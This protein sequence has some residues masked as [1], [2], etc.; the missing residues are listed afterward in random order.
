MRMYSSVIDDEFRS[1]IIQLPIVGAGILKKRIELVQGM[2][3][4][5]IAKGFDFSKKE[6][7][8]TDADKLEYCK[9]EEDL[10]E[11]WRKILKFQVLSRYLDALEDKAQTAKTSDQN[12][13]LPVAPDTREEKIADDLR[14]EASD[15]VLKSFE[16]F[17]TRLL[18]EDRD[19]H[20]DRYFNAVAQA[21]DPHTNYLPP[22]KKED[23]DIHMRGSLEGIGA[24]LR[25][26]GGYIKIV[27]VIPG[28]AADRQ[29]QLQ[30]E[31]IILKVAEGDGEPVDITDTRIR[32]AVALIR[33][34]KGTEVRLT[35]K[36]PDGSRIIIPIIRD[37]V[38]IE[39]T[40]VKATIIKDEKRSK[41]Y[42]YIK[43]PSFYRDF[44]RSMFSGPGRNV[45]DDMRQELKNLSTQKTD[46]LI[47][48]LRNNGGGALEDAVNVAG[49]FIKTGPIVQVK[50]SDGDIEVLADKDAAIGYDGPIVVLVSKFSASASEILAAALQDYGRAV[51]IGGEHTHGKG[52]VQT[53]IDLNNHIPFRNMEKFKPLGAL[54]ITTQKFY[55]ISGGS[56]QYR[57]VSP[58]IVL[59][60]LMQYMKSGEQYYDF[61]LPWD[62]VAPTSYSKWT[63]Q[64]ANLALLKSRSSQRVH[65]NQDFIEIAEE[66]EMAKERSEKTLRSLNIDEVRNDLEAERLRLKEKGER[67]GNNFHVSDFSDDFSNPME[68]KNEKEWAE[69]ISGDP[70]VK[71]ATFVLYDMV[72][73]KVGRSPVEQKLGSR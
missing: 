46:G 32:D 51:V 53:M 25:E 38:Q 68:G 13:N 30:A 70:Y 29:G 11:R 21:F 34:K 33:G 35:V 9:N 4:D 12:Q 63:K 67:G 69:K 40:F 60:D 55:R 23:F 66:A 73:A 72:D 39:E 54:K 45:T 56:T 41:N 65:D 43:I 50:D 31:D 64:T 17:F 15:K 7:I 18:N 44:N 16:D 1:G 6:S 20:Y 22:T 37:I 2:V 49:L 52:T 57:G 36:K 28:S 5:L 42:G 14:R 61:S 27:R 59:P 26:E 62:T 19:D 58:D 24:L 3:G 10:R 47:L 48:D 71:E 8:E